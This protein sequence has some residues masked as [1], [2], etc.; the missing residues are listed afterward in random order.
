M[1]THEF[2]G[3]VDNFAGTRILLDPLEPCPLILGMNQKHSKARP[4]RVDK[5]ADA[6][7]G[8]LM[9]RKA[10]ARARAEQTKTEKK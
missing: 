6:L 1:E 4:R 5:S 10:Q 7:R 2:Q 9:K 8:N 3:H